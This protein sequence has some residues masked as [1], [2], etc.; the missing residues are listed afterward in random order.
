MKN[1][2]IDDRF[3]QSAHSYQDLLEAYGLTAEHIAAAVKA[4]RDSKL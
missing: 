1:V 2:G 3:G 4:I